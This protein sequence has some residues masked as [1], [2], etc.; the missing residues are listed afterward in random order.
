V[1]E[2]LVALS[3]HSVETLSL[4][5]SSGETVEDETIA[6]IISICFLQLTCVKSKFRAR[7]MREEPRSPKEI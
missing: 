4:R 7:S 3:K 1:L 2:L 5:N 6:G